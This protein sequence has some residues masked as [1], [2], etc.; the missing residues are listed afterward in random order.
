LTGPRVPQV[1][2]VVRVALMMVAVTRMMLAAGVTVRLG[3][4]R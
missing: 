4:K 2:A 3:E 1:E